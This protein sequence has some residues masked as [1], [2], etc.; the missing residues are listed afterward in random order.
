MMLLSPVVVSR[1]VVML[2]LVEL[3][4]A[5]EDWLMQRVL[6]HAKQ[7]Y[8]FADTYRGVTEGW[9]WDVSNE[10][11]MVPDSNVTDYRRVDITG[12]TSEDVLNYA[13]LNSHYQTGLRNLI[14]RAILDHSDLNVE[15]CRLVDELP[16]DFQRRRMSVIVDY[17]GD[18]V[19]ICKGA[20]EEIMRLSP[21][22][23]VRGEG[24]KPRES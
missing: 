8:S 15:W 9:S 4:R 23:E 20:V 24:C 3:I 11:I 12:R 22:V 2:R 13:Y 7:L 19:L 6:E 17:E 16:F 14:D 10:F 5:R 18:H 1:V 21:H